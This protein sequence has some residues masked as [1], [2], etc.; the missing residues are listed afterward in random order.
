MPF[1]SAP[2]ICPLCQKTSVTRFI[3]DFKGQNDN[4]SLYQCSVC[5]G[6]FWAPFKNPGAQWYESGD[7]YNVKDEANPRQIHSY[8]KYFLASGQSLDKKTILDIGCGTGEFLAALEKRGALAY[9]TDIDP[10]AVAFAKKFYQPRHIFALAINDYFQQ[11]Q[12]AP[13]DIITAFEVFEHVDEPWT[14]LTFAQKSLRPG[15]KLI[16]STPSRRRFLINLAYW[17]YPYH[18][19]SRWD[20]T[21]IKK[22]TALAGFQS[23]KI[24]YL[25][26]FNQL[27]EVFLEFLA[28][29]LQFKKASGLKN[30]SQ[31][32]TASGFSLKRLIIKIV[33]R[34]GRFIG[35]IIIPYFLA[36]LAYPISLIFYPK[37]GL[38]Y[39]EASK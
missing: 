23:V 25:N 15:G 29:K 17:D 16:M 14:I 7:D 21:A 5:D 11:D 19:L 35:I 18:H 4:F 24:T 30:I 31:T 26:Q 8:H 28:K 33:Y 2:A 6:Q 20:E 13:Y 32:P 3:Q 34:T 39:I 9:G 38:M 27:K 37:A 22:I 1:Q 36:V 10:G 12:G